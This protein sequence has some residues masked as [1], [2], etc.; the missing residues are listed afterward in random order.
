MFNS[1]TSM[2]VEWSRVMETAITSLKPHN[3]TPWT[4]SETVERLLMFDDPFLLRSKQ[5]KRK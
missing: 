3:L 4:G 5:P 1:M 2:E